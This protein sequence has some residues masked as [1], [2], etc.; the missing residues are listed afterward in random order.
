MME[1]YRPGFYHE[2][3]QLSYKAEAIMKSQSSSPHRCL[4]DNSFFQTRNRLVSNHCQTASMATDQMLAGLRQAMLSGLLALVGCSSEPAPSPPNLTEAM[5]TTEEFSAAANPKPVI[6]PITPDQSQQRS[7]ATAASNSDITSNLSTSTNTPMVTPGISNPTLYVADEVN[8]PEEA[9]IIG[10]VVEGQARAYLQEAMTPISA[11]VVNDMV[12]QLPVTVTFCNQTDCVRVFAREKPET[13][14]DM[15]TAG[16]AD[17]EMMLMLDGTVHAHSSTTIPL[18][19]VDF[20]RT[21]W[22]AWKVEHPDTQVF[23]GE[24]ADKY[25]T[26]PTQ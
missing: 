9:M 17:N 14:I 16:F 26:K 11:H 3:D 1:S 15:K 8:L 6:S 20:V 4:P 22:I 13:T 10:C 2:T 18:K 7:T 5:K 12:G 25:L 24:L 21:L 19:D 23:L